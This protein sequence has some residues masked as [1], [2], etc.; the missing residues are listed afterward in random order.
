VGVN[1]TLTPP[2]RITLK[3]TPSKRKRKVQVLADDT[4]V[5]SHAGGA[6][7]S[8]LADRVGLTDALARALAPTRERASA[9][10][11]GRVLRDLAV[12][13]AAGGDCLADLGALR[14]Q[15]DLFGR[16]ASDATAWRAIS[17]ARAVGLDALRHARM[18]ARAHAW[19]MGARPERIVLD[20]DATLLTAHSEKEGAAPTRKRG[21]G[22][23]PMLCYLDQTE[24]ALSGILRP[25][26]AGSNTASDHITALADAIGQIPE[27]VFERTQEADGQGRILVRGDSAAATHDFLDAL[28]QMGCDFSVGFDLTEPVRQ[29]ILSVPEE[30]WQK[31]LTQKGEEREGAW[32]TELELDLGAWPEGSRAICRRERPHPGAQMSF[33]DHDGHRFQVVLT[34]QH[35]PDIVAI[36][37]RHRA[38]ARV[39]DRI[40]CA[41]DT[42]L[43]NLPFR[44]FHAN[45]VWLELVLMAQDLLAWAKALVLDGELARAEPKRLRYRLLHVAARITRSGRRVLLHLPASWPW[46]GALVAAF[47]RLR[48]LPAPAS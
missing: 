5:V 11:P 25:G 27:D 19:A 28:C 31:A 42:G 8:E 46:A 14:D 22:F 36:E 17:A 24:E 41:K 34:N 20:I 12:M 6:L 35:E 39:E 16:V 15:P 10:G 26:N 38:H 47:A 21:F 48:A 23:H 40:R 29:A 9:H 44:E 32:V 7:L 13:L 30:R 37:A 33:T 1:A 3:V 43:R 18:S 2:R 4:S 45:E